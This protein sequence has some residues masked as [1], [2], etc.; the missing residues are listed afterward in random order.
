MGKRKLSVGSDFAGRE[1]LTRR[2]LNL[3]GAVGG[4]GLVLRSTKVELDAGVGQLSATAKVAV[5]PTRV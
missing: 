4:R 1:E 2:L 5:R 3:I